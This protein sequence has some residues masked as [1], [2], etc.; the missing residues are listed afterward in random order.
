MAEDYVECLEF[1]RKFAAVY[2]R[3]R[4][5]PIMSCEYPKPEERG[6]GLFQAEWDYQ[7]S[8]ERGGRP[9]VFLLERRPYLAGDEPWT[10]RLFERKVEDIPITEG[11]PI[12]ISKHASGHI[13]ADSD[14]EGCWCEAE[15]HFL[16]GIEQAVCKRY[17]LSNYRRD[18]QRRFKGTGG[19]VL[20]YDGYS[21]WTPGRTSCSSATT[22]TCF[23]RTSRPRASI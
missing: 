2:E 20:V 4:M 15:G 14:I 11:I 1:R 8:W 7:I 3:D 17:D 6:H 9:K 16:E 13:F 18:A 21:P 19:S 12:E 10:L 23:A 22:S 5:G